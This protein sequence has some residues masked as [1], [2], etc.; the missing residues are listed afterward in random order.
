M[1]EWMLRE[2]G[3]D[4][5]RQIQS[6]LRCRGQRPQIQSSSPPAPTLIP[7]PPAS[8][9]REALASPVPTVHVVLAA[10]VVYG[11]DPQVSVC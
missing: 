4:A 3:K 8:R 7:S 10:D 1:H 5:T 11:S 2:R 6:A 9:A